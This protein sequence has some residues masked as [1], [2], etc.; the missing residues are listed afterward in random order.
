MDVHAVPL[1][2]CRAAPENRILIVDDEP[3]NVEFLTH[4]LGDEYGVVLTSTQ[5]RRAAEALDDIRPD[6]VILD[7]MM[8]DFDGC[9]FLQ[10]LR[11]WLPSDDWVPVLVATADT[12]KETRRRALAAGAAD[13]LTKPLSPAEVRLRVRNLLHTRALH[14]ALRGQNARLE[15]RVAE[16]TLELEEA[17]QEILERLARAAEYRDDDTGQHAQRVGRLAARLAQ[18]LGLPAESCELIRQAAPLHDIGKIGIPDMILV[19]P[20]PLTPDERALMET[21]AAV[22]ARILSGSRSAVLSLAEEIALTH[23]EW[24]DGA[25]YPNGLRGEEIPVSGRIVAVADVFDSLTHARPYKRAWT[26]REALA[27]LEAGAGRH[28]DPAVV[29][30]LLRVAH[31]TTALP[32]ECEPTH[33]PEPTPEELEARLR[34]L[35]MERDEVNRRIRS[36]RR[37]LEPGNRRARLTA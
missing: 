8:P 5:P 7:L 23:H 2:P 30:A 27:E 11:E 3:A 37:R 25:G 33:G 28:F 19:K 31:E 15:E 16:R 14:A 35:E 1:L 24:W 22:G 10:W 32:W 21:H 13:F 9:R 6:L 34:R 4:V 29:E 18:V 36:L 12:S 17:R 26:P 20:G